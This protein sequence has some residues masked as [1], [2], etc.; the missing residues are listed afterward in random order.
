M[1]GKRHPVHDHSGFNQGGT[2]SPNAIPQQD[3]P[4]PDG[5]HPNLS[6]HDALGLATDVELAAHT[7]DT[8]DAH[9]A[10][11]IS[12]VDAGAV[13]T[14]TDV[15]AALQELGAGRW[16]VVVSGSAPPVAVSTPSDD[17]WVYGWVA[18]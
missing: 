3:Y 11:A 16:E 12:I 2:L 6:D 13:F 9:D 15:E 17:D 10:S 5:S 7:S 14:G 4:S 8:A 18:G 1:S